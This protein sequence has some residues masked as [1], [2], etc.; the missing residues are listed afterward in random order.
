MTAPRVYDLFMFRDEL[1]M[2]EFRLREFEDTDTIHVLCESGTDHRGLPKPLYYAENKERFAPW[3]DRIVHVIADGLPLAGPLPALSR[4]T[5]DHRARPARPAWA[6]VEDQVRDSDVILLG[7]VDEFPPAEALEGTF[8]VATLSQR[9]AM[10]AVDWLVPRPHL[11]S[12]GRLRPV[13]A[14]EAAIGRAGRPLRLLR[15]PGRRLAHH[16]ARRSRRPAGEARNHLPPRNAPRRGGAD[17]LGHLLPHRA[18]IT[19]ATCNC[20]PSTWTR[21][22]RRRSTSGK[23]RPPGS[24]RES[25]A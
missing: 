17:R 1:D 9:L 16:V 5:V 18:S 21:R 11:C 15:P 22:G 10:Y 8:P 19:R 2:L 20:S 14:R 24:G 4:G 23:C 12:R 6:A 7:D 13:H 3:S 25:D